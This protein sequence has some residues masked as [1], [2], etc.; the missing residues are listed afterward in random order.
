M[1]D[2]IKVGQTLGRTGPGILDL[3]EENG[4]GMLVQ[5]N[6]GEVLFFQG[7][8]ADCA[9]VVRKGDIKLYC[10]S[11]DGKAHTYEILGAGRLVGATAHLHGGQHESTAEPLEDA[12]VYVIP[13]AE[14][15]HL[16]SSDPRFSMAVMTRI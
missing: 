2:A 6:K 7:D 13:R 9:F 12:D 15:T 11:L 5:Y 1:T 10:V 8:L 16:L 3:V 14:F 4:I